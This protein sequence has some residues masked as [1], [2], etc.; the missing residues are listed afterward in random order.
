MITVNLIG[1]Y[2]GGEEQGKGS[3]SILKFDKEGL[4]EGL[5]MY[6]LTIIDICTPLLVGP[7]IFVQLRYPLIGAPLIFVCLIRFVSL[8]SAHLK[9][10]LYIEI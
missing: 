7:L 10:A 3:E 5:N 8:I 6:Y 4:I 1:D 2:D 9:I